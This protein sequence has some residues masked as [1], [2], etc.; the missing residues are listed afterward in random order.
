M[1]VP[2]QC[3]EASDQSLIP[4]VVVVLEEIVVVVVVVV[5]AAA[6]VLE[7]VEAKVVVDEIGEVVVVG[8]IILSCIPRVTK[9]AHYTDEERCGNVGEN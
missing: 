8:H 5:V 6:V 4:V 7:V 1:S 3:T 9:A 2:S